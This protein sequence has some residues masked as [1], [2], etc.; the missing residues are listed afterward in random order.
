MDKLTRQLETFFP[1][2]LAVAAEGFSRNLVEVYGRGYG[3]SREEWRLLFLLAGEDQVTSRDLSR[4]STLD[5]VQ[6]SRA[7]QKLEDKGLITRNIAPDD[8]RLRVY[9]CTEKGRDLFANALPQVE[10]RST[11][12]LH[13]MT[14]EDRAALE[15]GLAALTDA[16]AKRIGLP[17]NDD[18]PLP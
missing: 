11:E 5:R 10:A 9:A 6:V 16:I 17:E 3:L 1:Y 14:P 12:I 18:A 15:R 8:R 2:R 4:R 13:A 7:S